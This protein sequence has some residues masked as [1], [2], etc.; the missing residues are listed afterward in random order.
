MGH[1]VSEPLFF[2]FNCFLHHNIGTSLFYFLF[3]F[4]SYLGS[5]GIP[6]VRPPVYI[7]VLKRSKVVFDPGCEATI[8]TTNGTPL[9]GMLVS[10]STQ[11]YTVLNEHIYNRYYWRFQWRQ[12][13]QMHHFPR[14]IHGTHLLSR[15]HLQ[16]NVR[17]PFHWR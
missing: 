15:G 11:R 14:R 13:S 16:R 5:Y 12:A 6:V 7:P 8:D 4:R 2:E 17:P 3:P 10:P 1:L 9:Q